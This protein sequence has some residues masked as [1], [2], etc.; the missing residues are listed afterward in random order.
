M[1][2][3]SCV[4]VRVLV[5]SFSLLLCM[6]IVGV[7]VLVFVLVR[8]ICISLCWC[9]IWLMLCVRGRL[10]LHSQVVVIMDMPSR[11]VS[12]SVFPPWSRS[13]YVCLSVSFC[14]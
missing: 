3:V 11:Y 5:V 1:Y 13:W 2:V 12:V 6:S 14:V 7:P 10:Q 8:V 9:H 4:G